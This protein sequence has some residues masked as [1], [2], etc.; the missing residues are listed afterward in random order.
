[1]KNK[2][3]VWAGLP[4]Y[5]SHQCLAVSYTTSSELSSRKERKENIEMSVVSGHHTHTHC[6]VWSDINIKY[7]FT[8]TRLDN[9]VNKMNV[10]ST[11]KEYNQV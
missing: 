6:L 8:L 3:I 5:T 1:M 9:V 10:N 2:S 4:D 7:I 11:D